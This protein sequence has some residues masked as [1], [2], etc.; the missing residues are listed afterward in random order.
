MLIRMPNISWE[1]AGETTALDFAAAIVQRSEHPID[2]VKLQKLLY[3]VQAAHLAW[4]DSPAF[5]EPIQAWVYGPVIPR[6][7]GHYKQFGP[8]PITRAT[9]GS[10]QYLSTRQLRVVD[11]VLVDYSDIQSFD[12]ATM[13]KKEGMPWVR[14]REGLA[15][16]E[17]SDEEIPVTL[18]RAW[19]RKHGLPLHS[20][21]S[22]EEAAVALRFFDGDPDAFRELLR[23]NA[24]D[25]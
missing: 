5:D 19:H 18:I 24:E 9:G 8:Q 12:L 11:H 16:D 2:H 7:G 20:E 17:P 22:E 3:L 10:Q 15:P 13:L 14:I 4:Y 21:P 23:L 1:T 6:V 25:R